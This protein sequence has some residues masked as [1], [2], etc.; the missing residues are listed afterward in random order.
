MKPRSIGAACIVSIAVLLIAAALP[1]CAYFNTLYN[2]RR[3]YR[4]AEKTQG[5]EEAGG[6]GQRDKYK[7]VVKKCAQMIQDFPKSRWVDDA[8]FLMGKALFRQGEYDK[9]IRQFQ[10]ILTN[11]PESDYAP[12]ALYWLGLSH[13]MKQNY[14]QALADTDRFLKEYPGHE[15][16]YD[17][18]FLG[19]DIK[20]A[21]ED[22]EG[23]LDYYGRVADEA[24]KRSGKRR[25]RATRRCSARGF[26]GKCAMIYRSPSENATRRRANAVRRSPCSTS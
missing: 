25:R 17:A 13:Y 23:A 16:R 18:F 15:L 12:Q 2:A 5:Q 10:E 7:D 26:L 21:M 14:A 22:F 6:R 1:S 24:K 9:A 11:F 4:E 19:G 20:R 3:I 8:V